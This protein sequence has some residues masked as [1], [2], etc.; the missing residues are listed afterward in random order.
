MAKT[1][2]QKQQEVQAL[3]EKIKQSKAGVLVSYEGLSVGQTTELRRALREA[4]V[5]LTMIKKRLL[6][7]ALEEAG[8][9]DAEVATHDKNVSIALSEDDE[10]AA[11]KALAA[12]AKDHSE[13]MSLRGGV[14]EGSFVDEA[15]VLALSK[16]PSKEELLAKMVGS[17]KSPLSGL[18]GVLQGNARQLVQVLYAIKEAKA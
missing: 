9:K 6:K 10:V 3:V 8:I 14:L 11:A 12:F 17:L 13:Q 15:Q 1:R 16:L 2:E 4:G 18:V 5:S 7:I